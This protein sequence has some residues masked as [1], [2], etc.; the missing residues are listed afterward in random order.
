M[1]MKTETIN[2]NVNAIISYREGLG[3][4]YKGLFD[5]M[6]MTAK[7]HAK[8]GGSSKLNMLETI[9]MGVVL[10]QQKEIAKLKEFVGIATNPA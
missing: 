6:L 7:S 1:M 3:T 9:L 8:A 4:E 5:E 2:E 10:E